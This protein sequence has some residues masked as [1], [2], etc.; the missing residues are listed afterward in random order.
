MAEPSSR[1]VR[2]VSTQGYRPRRPPV[3]VEDKDACA[4]YAS[5]QKDATPAHEPIPTALTA[6]Q[7]ML[8][9]AGNVDGEGDGCGVLV[10]IPR[11]IWAEEIRAAGAASHLALDPQFAVGHIFISRKGGNAEETKARAPRDHEPL[12]AARAG[13]APGRA[14]NSAALGPTAREEEPHLLAGRRPDRRGAAVLRDAAIELEQ[15]LDVHVASFSID[16]C[17]YKVMGAPQVLG[18][19]FPDLLDERAETVALLGHNRYS[20]NTWPSFMRVQPFSVLGHNGEIN[21]IAR[22]RA[23]GAHAG[24]ADPRRLLGLAGPQPADRDAHPPPRAVAAGGDGAGGAA[25]RQRDPAAP[26]GPARLLHVP[27][28]GDRAVRTG[29]RSP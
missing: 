2:Y 21:T 25:D 20:T 23:G 9:R 10:D 18:N 8:H 11:R 6:L 19:Y 4:L 12:R 14:S 24:R 26:G 28:P 15:Q 22:L 13:R 29:S 3:T 5:V 17:V 16:T 1:G 27:A 7:K